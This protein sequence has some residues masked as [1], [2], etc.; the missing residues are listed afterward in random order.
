MLLRAGR[1]DEARP[2]LATMVEECERRGMLASA[3][4]MRA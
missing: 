2:V 3:T 1:D 4:A